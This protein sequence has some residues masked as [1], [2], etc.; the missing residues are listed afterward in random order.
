MRKAQTSRNSPL[1]RRARPQPAR[2]GAT[3][4]PVIDKNRILS[5]SVIMERQKRTDLNIRT[6]NKWVKDGWQWGKP[7]GHEEFVKAKNG[8]CNALLSPNKFVPKEWFPPL[9]GKRLP[10]LASGGGRQM[11]VFAAL[12][13]DCAALDYSEERLASER[14]VAERESYPMTIVKADMTERFPFPG[15]MF[16][17]IFHPASNCYVENVRHIWN[18]RFRVLKK[19]GVL[20]AG[21]NNGICYLLDD[22]ENLPLVVVNKLPYNP[23][24]DHALYEKINWEYDNIQ[25]SHSL[26]EQIGVKSRFYF[27]RSV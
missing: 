9:K 17:V 23:L 7:I 22:S 3:R 8:E 18:E 19:G 27:N 1:A 6:I 4:I 21:M 11:P 5:Y 13:A 14:Y 2:S 12:G 16:D 26:E 24:K 10:G 25:F 15:E 20:L